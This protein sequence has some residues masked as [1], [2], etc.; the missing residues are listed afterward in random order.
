MSRINS[1]EESRCQFLMYILRGEAMFSLRLEQ[2]ACVIHI[3]EL[4]S[5][6]IMGFFS[7]YVFYFCTQINLT[8]CEYSIHINAHMYSSTSLQVMG[9]IAGVNTASL[10]GYLHSTKTRARWAEGFHELNGHV[11]DLERDGLRQVV[12]CPRHTMR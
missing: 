3:I 10:G 4:L 5:F 9:E 12:L 8:G 11:F 2:Q 1:K 7:L 6:T